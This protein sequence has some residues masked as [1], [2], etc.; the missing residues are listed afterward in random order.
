MQFFGIELSRVKHF[1][2]ASL[3]TQ[4]YLFLN[5]H[6]NRYGQLLYILSAR[7]IQDIS[8]HLYFVFILH[9]G[10]R[11]PPPEHGNIYQVGRHELDPYTCALLFPSLFSIRTPT[12]SRGPDDLFARIVVVVGG[13]VVVYIGFYPSPSSRRRGMSKSPPRH[14]IIYAFGFPSPA[15]PAAPLY[16]RR[17]GDGT[18]SVGRGPRARRDFILFIFLLFLLK[19]QRQIPRRVRKLVVCI[20]TYIYIFINVYR[21]ARW[22]VEANKILKRGRAA[23]P[24]SSPVRTTAAPRRRR[25][26][27]LNI[28][29]NLLPNLCELS[30]GRG[31][32]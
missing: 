25:F 18:E 29:D 6:E 20:Q 22:R 19:A 12:P 30:S 7:V 9:T 4:I 31:K 13:V 2:K 16:R 15:G 26:D 32:K 11:G 3:R 21:C 28:Y 23:P 1:I 17:R 24:S 27:A 10:R 8:I 5:F 14:R